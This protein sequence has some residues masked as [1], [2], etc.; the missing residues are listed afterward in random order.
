M[1]VRKTLTVLAVGLAVL[2]TGAVASA[3]PPKTK[4]DHEALQAKYE[5]LAADQEAIVAEH[6]QMK[7]DKKA[8]QATLP[9]QTREKTIAEME[10]H[11]DA[12]ISGAK[13]LGGD[14]AAMAQWHKMRAEELEK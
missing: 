10:E 4:A 14:Y 13:K 9:K 6:T 2:A 5:K 11:C 3:K 12:I 7:K 1:K 8:I